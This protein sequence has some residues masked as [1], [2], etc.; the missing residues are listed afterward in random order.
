MACVRPHSDCLQLLYCVLELLL[1][2]SDEHCHHHAMSIAVR[3]GVVWYAGLSKLFKYAS[4]VVLLGFCLFVAAA[5][6]R[7][8]CL[9]IVCIFYTNSCREGV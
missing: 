5:C 1:L 4:Q 7:M 3:T 6:V 2:V 8:L 9:L